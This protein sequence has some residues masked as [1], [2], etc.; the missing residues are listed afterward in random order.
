M[1]F[2][3]VLLRLLLLALCLNTTVG[4]ALHSAHH[5][6]AH[7]ATGALAQVAGDEQA[8]DQG[9]SG[10]DETEFGACDY[11]RAYTALSLFLDAP[12]TVALPILAGTEPR[13]V[14]ALGF[15][16]HPE[17]WR[18]AARDPPAAA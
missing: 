1:R 10:S 12:G 14:F 18:F 13:R 6:G 3:R 16:P 11:C 2:Q 17:S 4:M 5:L 7:A 9:S 8:A 15:V